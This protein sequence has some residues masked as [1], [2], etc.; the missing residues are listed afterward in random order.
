[1]VVYIEYV[2]LDNLVIDYLL[3]KST[4]II[5]NLSVKKKRLV[6]VSVLGATFSLFY[7]LISA[8]RVIV[9]FIKLLFGL[10]MVTLCKAYA[11]VKEFYITALVFFT[12]TFLTGGAII[13]L[14]NLLGLEYSQEI[15]VALMIAPVY[16]ILK[17]GVSVIKHIY[18]KRHVASLTFFVEITALNKTVCAQGFLD[19]GNLLF[20]GDSPVIV[21]SKTLFKSLLGGSG[22]PKPKKIKVST[23]NGVSEKLSFKCEKL[24]IKDKGSPNIF[25]NVTA[26][27]TEK[28]TVDGV[29]VILHPALFEVKNV[30]ETKSQTA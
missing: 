16:V 12:L 24:V 11:S 18:S 1:M 22:L 19:T 8:H 15:S 2:I 6:A 23:V 17:I 26:I 5:T 7:P 13:G 9:F 10:L 14:Y 4:F 20:D 3:L 21:L 25:N 29:Q 30:K 28:I 27:V